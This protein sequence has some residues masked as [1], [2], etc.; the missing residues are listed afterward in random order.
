MV[1]VSAPAPVYV[2]WD[3]G[4]SNGANSRRARGGRCRR[5]LAAANVSASDKEAHSVLAEDIR[6]TFSFGERSEEV[7]ALKGAS[8]RV[9]RGTLHMLLGPN[10][11]GKARVSAEAGPPLCFRH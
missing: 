11:C 2:H 10:G 6:V 4:R 7:Q 3:L 5:V 9:A 8:L 1:T